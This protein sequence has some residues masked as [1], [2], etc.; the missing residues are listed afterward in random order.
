MRTQ[1]TDTGVKLWLSA[2]DTYRWATR[3]RH[4]GRVVNWPAIAYSPNSTRADW[5]T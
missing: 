3:P 5:L 1:I 4:L 2:N